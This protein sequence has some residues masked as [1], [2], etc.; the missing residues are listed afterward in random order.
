MVTLAPEERAAIKKARLG[1]DWEQKDLARR[2]GVSPAT[3]S[4]LEGTRSKQVRLV[5][6][7]KIRRVLSLDAEAAA[8]ADD[9]GDLARA[10]I[11]EAALGLDAR[12]L[13]LA[14]QMI[15]ELAAKSRKSG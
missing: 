6:L 1:R 11:Y 7:V 2:V 10:R 3:I 8:I 12:Q 5:L 15:E 13:D 9:K 4:N 14:A